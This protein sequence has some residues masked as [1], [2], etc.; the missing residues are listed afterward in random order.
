MHI[1][2]AVDDSMGLLFNNRRQ[3][4]DCELIRRIIKEYGSNLYIHPFSADLFEDS[5]AVLTCD[6]NFLEKAGEDA[7]CF[8]E[9]VSVKP[10]VDSVQSVV[11]YKWNRAYP[12]DFFFD[13]PLEG[14]F[15]VTKQTDF[16]GTSHDDITQ[17]VYTR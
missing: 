11:L 8:V 15:A 4:K 16:V 9:N 5:E 17:E 3:S 1:I 7:Y 10:F 2:A 12:G 14:V 13:L 6:E